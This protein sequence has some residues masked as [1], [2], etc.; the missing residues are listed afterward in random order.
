MTLVML[1]GPSGSGKSTL[2]KEYIDNGFTYINQDLLGPDHLPLFHQALKEGKDIILDRMNFNVAQR[3]RYLDPAKAS[4]Y[5]TKIIVLH[6][7]YDTCLQRCIDRKDHLTIKDEATARKALHMFFIKYE[8][9]EDSEADEVVRRWPNHKKSLAICCDLDG[10][11]CDIDHRLHFMK[12][13]K[14]DW[15]GFFAGIPEDKPNYWCSSILRAMSQEYNHKIV[16]CSGRPDD[17]RE[18]TVSWLKEHDLYNLN[19]PVRGNREELFHLYMRHAGDYRSDE[20]VKQNILDFEL[21]TRFNIFF[22]IDDR[23]SVCR[24]WR[25][26]GLTVLQCNDKEF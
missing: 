12:Q 23:P 22:C 10:T 15:K 8:R 24:M 9:V 2:S 4:N 20:I 19:D 16:F 7:S 11:L 21:K 5:Q 18:S 26:N 1:V 6:E 17:V 25:R 14:K 3:R 13:D